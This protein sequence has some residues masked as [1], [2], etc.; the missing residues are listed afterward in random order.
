M[1]KVT[2]ADLAA[3]VAALRADLEALRA[4]LATEVRTRSLVVVDDAGDERISTFID[5]EF[6][7]LEVRISDDGNAFGDDDP[8]DAYVTIDAQLDTVGT[9]DGKPAVVAQVMCTTGTDAFAILKQRTTR[10][11]TGR[12]RTI[13]DRATLCL[14]Q[15]R[16]QACYEDGVVNTAAKSSIDIG[17]Q[18]VVER[19]VG[20]EV[21]AY[22]PMQRV[23]R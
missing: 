11:G 18:G 7:R 19:A 1:T 6:T 2:D 17:P 20:D 16:S 21:I 14:M 3:E 15:Q 8:R 12:H 9:R 5:D 13:I 10:T 4:E 22:A 23:V